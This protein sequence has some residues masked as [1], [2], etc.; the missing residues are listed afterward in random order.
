MG[1][2]VMGWEGWEGR[3]EEGMGR[4]GGKGRVGCDERNG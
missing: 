4:V 2:Y 1:M 3:G